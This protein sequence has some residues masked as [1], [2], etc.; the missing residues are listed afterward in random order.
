M[1][2]DIGKLHLD[3]IHC[4]IDMLLQRQDTNARQFTTADL[5]AHVNDHWQLKIRV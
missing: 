4:F 2:E 1:I 5:K 3:D